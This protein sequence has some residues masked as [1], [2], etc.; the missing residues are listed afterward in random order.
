MFLVFSAHEIQITNEDAGEFSAEISD[1]LRTPMTPKMLAIS[2]RN[3]K[4][5]MN[6]GFYIEICLD[7]ESLVESAQIDT[8]I[9]VRFA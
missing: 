5:W 2:L 9:E 4:S 1:Q 3:Y 6:T 8:E 7:I